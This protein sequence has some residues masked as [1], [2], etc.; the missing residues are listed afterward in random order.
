[1]SKPSAI[2]HRSFCKHH[3]LWL[4]VR[5]YLSA[6][7]LSEVCAAVVETASAG[8][9]A[10]DDL[11]DQRSTGD[12]SLANWA[13]RM[14]PSEGE[15]QSYLKRLVQVVAWQG[16]QAPGFY[17]RQ[18]EPNE[19]AIMAALETAMTLGHVD[20]TSIAN[21][22]P[23][24]GSCPASLEALVATMLK[25]KASLE[26][27]PFEI[28]FDP[29]VEAS[30][31][32]AAILI[33]HLGDLCGDLDRWDVA[34]VLYG[35][36]ASTL[37]QCLESAWSDLKASLATMLS[38]S[39]AAALRITEGPAA[40]AEVLEVLLD[41][42]TIDGDVLALVNATPD[43]M[44]AH[45][46]LDAP[47]F[48]HD[49]R[50]SVVL[51]P[52]LVN[53]HPLS[54]ALSYWT[55]QQFS[56][57][58]RWFWAVLRRQIALGA[59]TYS[60]DTKAY[61]AL[62]LIDEMEA[63]LGTNRSVSTFKMAIRLLVESGRYQSVARSKWNDA[64]VE[65]YVEESHVEA[66]VSLTQRYQ[67]AAT[68]R[69]MVVVALF[70]KWLGGLPADQASAAMAMISFLTE[71]AR[72]HPR[73]FFSDRNIGGAAMKSLKSV[74]EARPEFRPMSASK[75]AHAVLGALESA[76]ILAIGDAIETAH[77]YLDDF[78]HQLL[79]R[80][81][82]RIVTI[83][84]ATESGGGPWPIIRP[85]LAFLS[86]PS[87]MRRAI[88]GSEF[89]DRI[90]A[91][92]LR[93]SLDNESEHGAVMYLLRDLDPAFVKGKVDSERLDT[94]VAGLRE[95]ALQVNSS[96]AVGAI[97]ALLVAPAV[98]RRRGF[99]DALAGLRAALESVRAGRPN[100]AFADAYHPLLLLAQNRAELAR[101]L[102]LSE[103]VVA[104][105]ALPLLPLVQKIW[106]LAAREPL[107]FSGFAIPPRTAPNA[108]L[109]HNWAFASL[110]FAQSLGELPAM[111][112]AMRDAADHPE[113]G[114]AIAVARAI[115]V[116]AGDPETFDQEVIGAEGR[117]AFYAA[118]GQRIVL[119]R[120]LTGEVR[121]AGAKIMLDR[122]LRVG[123]HGLD[124]AL[125]FAALEWNV[126]VDPASSDAISYR[127]RLR[128]DRSLRMSLMPLYDRL[129]RERD[130]FAGQND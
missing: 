70:E 36:A 98:A 97:Q 39:R 116:S 12:P 48:Q 33:K 11:W 6:D 49:K 123:P 107:I 15:L 22:R 19:L 104:K 121:E 14:K 124:A 42:A 4:V 9:I 28:N 32:L 37:A 81:A 66:V 129:T 80:V 44:A 114:K 117:D 31:P 65:A 35:D 23:E 75:V 105:M 113:L 122:C 109:V 30:S 101:G 91:E 63:K 77:V 99:D 1:M 61:Y 93:L 110:A 64:L 50:G 94:I 16:D 45:Y 54:H 21:F 5:H 25:L 29:I 69:T 17:E 26:G 79:D 103:A 92:L 56:E 43:E 27:S 86:S 8:S 18:G 7:L 52:Q 34:L 47:T 78:D 24:G 126:D 76:D 95:R 73:A 96:A 13:I 106:E 128:N 67:G 71:K 108:V 38:Q 130:F 62:C 83:T 3:L 58:H 60:R 46:A 90:V 119:L 40:A 57:A 53:A 74:G 2:R 120:A 82:E 112:A 88:P 55:D 118:L 10:I 111:M 51:A 85:A 72:D 68:E 102:G 87:V 41:R 100:L 89:G 127:E 125:F 20:L 115:R 59:A 84:E